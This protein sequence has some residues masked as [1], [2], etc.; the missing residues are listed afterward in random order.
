MVYPLVV[1]AALAIGVGWQLGP[2]GVQNLLEQARPAGTGLA[3][4]GALLTDLRYPNEYDAHHFHPLA[5]IVASTMALTGFVLATLFYGL[6]IL[7]PTEVQRQFVPIY[8]L[9]RNK[10]YFDEIYEVIFIQPCHFV[11][12]RIADFDKHV[13]DEFIHF[14][15]RAA[16]AIA[17]LDDLIDRYIVDGVVNWFAR[18]TH[19]VGLGL[20]TAQT[21]QLRQYILFIV[22][23]TVAL[24]VLISYGLAAP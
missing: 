5:T 17:R 22:V 14:L 9:L 20:R 2:I 15:A 23:G 19:A 7:D 4:Q 3:H 12:R 10:W 24:F 18:W 21:G 16:V 6:R 8:R 11:A 1:L 13:I